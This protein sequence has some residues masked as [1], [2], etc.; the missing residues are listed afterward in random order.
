V[1]DSLAVFGFPTTASI[2]RMAL[3]AV[4]VAVWTVIVLAAGR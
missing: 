2:D 3:G 1:G 4:T